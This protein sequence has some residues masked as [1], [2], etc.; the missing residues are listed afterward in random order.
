MPPE[1][2]NSDPPSDL[3]GNRLLWDLAGA[4]L[5]WWT[6]RSE[7]V[8]LRLGDVLH[9]PGERP[10][11]AWFPT[12]ALVSLLHVLEEGSATEVATI[13]GEGMVG[14]PVLLGASGMSSRAVVHS[15]GRAIR[16]AM[17]WMRQAFD[18][19]GPPTKLLLRYVHALTTQMAQT[20][21]CNRHH[22]LAPRVACWLMRNFERSAGDELTMTQEWA[23]QMLGVRREGVTE[24]VGRLQQRGLVHNRRGH[25]RLVD[26]KG[27]EAQACECYRVVRSVYEEMLP[28]PGRP[29][30]PDDA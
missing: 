16:V 15:S 18:R 20:A 22:A 8:E 13:G 5:P 4:N 1:L 23:A 26:A 10:P 24:A 28:P 19:G 27:L 17:L 11:Y 21:V 30:P 3:Q 25:I 12:T 2:E 29:V 7:V 6:Q 9:E 14:V